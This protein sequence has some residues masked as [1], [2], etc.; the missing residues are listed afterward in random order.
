MGSSQVTETTLQLIQRLLYDGPPLVRRAD[1][2]SLDSICV[3]RFSISSRRLPLCFDSL[4]GVYRNPWGNNSS[5]IL[6]Y[7]A[8]LMMCGRVDEFAELIERMFLIC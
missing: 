3:L 5:C 4:P 8:D 2:D 1:G 6:R 7:F